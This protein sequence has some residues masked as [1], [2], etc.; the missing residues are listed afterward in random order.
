MSRTQ[1]AQQLKDLATRAGQGDREAETALAEILSPRFLTMMSARTR[2]RDLAR[3]LAQE[4]WIAFMVTLRRGPATEIQDVGAFA[5]GVARNVANSRFRGLSR[6]RELAP[7]PPDLA[8]P[9]TLEWERNA[10]ERMVERVLA[11]VDEVDR[12]ILAAFFV[13]GRESEEIGTLVGL[14]AAAVRQRKV[15][16]LRKLAE[17]PDLLSQLGPRRTTGS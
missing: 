7:L 2:N 8:A 1:E 11:E 6:N 16:I 4:A 5:W 17:N 3:D 12:K 13:E 14:T 15:R 9:P 10:R